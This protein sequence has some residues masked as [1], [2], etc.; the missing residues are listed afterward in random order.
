MGR[1][2]LMV[3][4]QSLSISRNA[5]GEDIV[6]SDSPG[7]GKLGTKVECDYCEREATMW[8]DALVLRHNHCPDGWKIVAT[9]DDFTF[10]DKKIV[11][12]NKTKDACPECVRAEGMND[13]G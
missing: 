6:V 11:G 10:W 1:V 4:K 7:Q 3:G 8:D 9:L 2:Y 13:D 5:R 12:L